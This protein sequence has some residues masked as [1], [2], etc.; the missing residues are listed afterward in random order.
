MPF[1]V[2]FPLR[3]LSFLVGF[4]LVFYVLLSVIRTFV[5]PRSAPD[6]LV[7]LVFITMRRIFDLRTSI[8]QEYERRDEIMALY[9][10]FTLV[11]LPAVWL[12]CVLVSYMAMFWATTGQPLYALYKISG[13]S[14]F[15]LGYAVF[16]DFVTTSLIFTESAI[17]LF[18]IALLI[19]YLPT[20]Y[21]AFSKREM[22]V[23]MLEIRAGSPPSALEM[24]TRFYRLNRMDKLS[25][26]WVAW[27]LW[28]VELDESHTSLAA[29]SFFRSPQPDRSWITAAGTILD[30]AALV[31]S[32]VDIPRDAQAEL[33]I[34]AGYIALRHICDFFGI[35]YNPD[36]K[37]DEPIS[38][39]QEEF[40]EVYDKLAEVGVPLKSDRE[41]AWRDFRG[42]RVNYDSVLIHLAG[43][44]MAP[45]TQ[46]SSDRAV[47]IRASFK[48]SKKKAS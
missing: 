28:F 35:Y 25:E 38:I 24:F 6:K 19:A 26:L 45:W 21:A 15:T 4:S 9:A 10:P 43:L 41:Q 17:G 47:R 29:L 20:M 48:M 34:R 30:A 42:W 14:L 44:T 36:P 5:L 32:T 2:L 31:A 8:E 46:W 18:L 23:T 37:P 40:D 13:S 16:D 33:C 39:A 3:V 1:Y 7:R 27:E 22:A 11:I 12:V